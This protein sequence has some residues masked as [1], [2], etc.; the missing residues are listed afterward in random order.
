[1][2]LF[3]TIGDHFVSIASVFRE[4]DSAYPLGGCSVWWTATKRAGVLDDQ[5]IARTYWDA[6][7]THEGIEIVQPNSGELTVTLNPEQTALFSP[8]S[9]YYDLQI[10][11][12]AGRIVTIDRGVLVARWSPTTRT[13]TP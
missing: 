1:M 2:T 8:G 7:G 13:T 6:L 3:L 12:A 10:H 5:A 11:D 4:D 9:Y